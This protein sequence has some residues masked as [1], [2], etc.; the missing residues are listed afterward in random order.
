VPN[1]LCAGRCLSADRSGFASARV[2]PAAMATGQA[3]G[4][5]AAWRAR[6]KKIDKSACLSQVSLV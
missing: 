6:N 2:L 3:A 5:I 1:L 4:T